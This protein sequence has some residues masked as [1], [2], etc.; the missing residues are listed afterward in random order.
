MDVTLLAAALTFLL[1]VISWLV[2]PRPAA[3]GLEVSAEPA[4]GPL[5]AEP[6]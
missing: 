3:A 2:L 5:R 4:A 1:L 6:A